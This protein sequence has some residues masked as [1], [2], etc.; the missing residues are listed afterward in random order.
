VNCSPTSHSLRAIDTS[1][2]IFVEL[3]PIDFKNAALDGFDASIPSVSN[4]IPKIKINN[5][6]IFTEFVAWRP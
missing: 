1:K 4:T 2:L 5:D 6:Y 3:V